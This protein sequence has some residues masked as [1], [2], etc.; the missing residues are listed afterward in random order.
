MPAPAPL[1]TQLTRTHRPSSPRLA[2]HSARVN[3]TVR[4]PSHRRFLYAATPRHIGRTVCA[5]L[6]EDRSGRSSRVARVPRASTPVH[7]PGSARQRARAFTSPGAP[8]PRI[9]ATS[10]YG[11]SHARQ[12]RA[13]RAG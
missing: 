4:P 3:A 5:R 13:P 7:F 10:P 2:L 11:A 6:R 8:S 12:T 1:V 9:T